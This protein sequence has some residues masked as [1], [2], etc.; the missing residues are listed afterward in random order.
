MELAASQDVAPLFDP[1]GFILA[2]S[3][4]TR[5]PAMAPTTGATLETAYDPS[6]QPTPTRDAHHLD[7]DEPSFIIGEPS[8]EAAAGSAR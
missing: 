1:L 6:P 8:G 3:R 7:A 2:G 4:A 5:V